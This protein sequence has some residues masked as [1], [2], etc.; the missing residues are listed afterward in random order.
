MLGDVH[1]SRKIE[2]PHQTDIRLNKKS[3]TKSRSTSSIS[4]YH[5]LLNIILHLCNKKKCCPEKMIAQHYQKL[6]HG[7]QEFTLLNNCNNH[8]FCNF[9]SQVV[10]GSN[11][12]FIKHLF[13]CQ[14]LDAE[15]FI[16]FFWHE[17]ASYSLHSHPFPKSTSA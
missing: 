8:A 15:I 1:I 5:L 13:Q 6:L 2:T 10:V 12:E 17:E 11:K 14:F 4:H 3:L 9:I 16:L 7:Q